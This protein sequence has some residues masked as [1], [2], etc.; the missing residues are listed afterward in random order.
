ML[1]PPHRH[2]RQPTTRWARPARPQVAL[3][4]RQNWQGT[5]ARWV[6]RQG[7]ISL[8][9]HLIAFTAFTVGAFTVKT[10]LGCAV[11]G[12]TA[13]WMENNVREPD[14]P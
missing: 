11:L 9:L 14:H 6:M 1:R 4:L 3:L 7:A 5:I 2:P 12:V 8:A 10:W 13:L